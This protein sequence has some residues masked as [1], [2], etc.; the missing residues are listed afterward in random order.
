ME[1]SNMLYS[2]GYRLGPRIGKGSYAKVKV[3]E[4]IADSRILAAKIICRR[5]APKEF[6]EK[7]LPRE[8]SVLLSLSHTNIIRIFEIMQTLDMVCIIM[9]Y[10]ERGDL[11]DYIKR[12]GA[13]EENVAGHVFAQVCQGVAY[14]HGRE[15]C[16]RDLKCENILLRRDMT[17]ILSDFGF[18]RTLPNNS[19]LSSTYCGSAAYASP[20]LLRGKP[21]RPLQSDIWSLGCIVFIMV[22]GQMPFYDK[23][24]KKMMYRQLKGKVNFPEQRHVSD[25]CKS[26]IS[27]T[28][29]PNS[30]LRHNISSM[31][32]HPWLQPYV[33][34]IN[35]RAADFSSGA[36]GGTGVLQAAEA[37]P[38]VSAGQDK[39]APHSVTAG[40]D[41]VAPQEENAGGTSGRIKSP[42]VMG[43]ELSTGSNTS[44]LD[45]KSSFTSIDSE[46]DAN[47]TFLP[48]DNK[49]LCRMPGKA[50]IA[51]GK[52]EVKLQ[53]NLCHGGN[54]SST[55]VDQTFSS[56]LASALKMLGGARAS[57]T[58]V[59]L[60]DCHLAQVKHESPSHAR[61]KA[62][63]AEEKKSDQNF[64]MNIK[65][66][67][68]VPPTKNRALHE[69]TATPR[70]IGTSAHTTGSL[71]AAEVGVIRIAGSKSWM[72]EK[73]KTTL[74]SFNPTSVPAHRSLLKTATTATDVS[75]ENT[76][77]YQEGLV[78]QMR[79]IFESKEVS[80]LTNQRNNISN[81]NT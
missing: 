66:I 34:Q 52:P 19:F 16:H 53:E 67:L 28:L 29:E 13:L 70:N 55:A 23:N 75:E 11:L 37:P 49:S 39:V 78:T 64:K 57:S 17:A 54:V 26:L 44:T 15:I 36:P 56:G 31:L 4:K 27:G 1:V 72:N 45:E 2:R 79:R 74:T 60:Q 51:F 25:S 58:S 24:T 76:R 30:D 22:T 21:Y 20:E 42:T 68:Q 35:Q 80:T 3:V 62:Q 40:Q 47:Q 10:A 6:L 8:L 9:E 43:K 61:I 41:K 38:L 18:S 48:L 69:Q 81:K 32:A 5:R 50:C 65:K 7:F 71:E 59:D 46:D 77:S 12:R 73:A 33:L 14:L 63:R